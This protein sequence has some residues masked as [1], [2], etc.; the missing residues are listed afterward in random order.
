MALVTLPKKKGAVLRGSLWGVCKHKATLLL[1]IQKQASSGESKALFQ[2]L[3]SRTALN[4]AETNQ[5]ASP[6]LVAGEGQVLERG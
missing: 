3:Q 1:F 2:S 6:A 4:E 5:D